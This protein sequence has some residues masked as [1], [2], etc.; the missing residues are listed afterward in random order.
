MLR[1]PLDVE[2]NLANLTVNVETTKESNDI[3]IEV[4]DDI[5]LQPKE[6]RVVSTV[7]FS[8]SSYSCSV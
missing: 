8:F 2:I 6:T 1:N 3:E 7:S 5:F 4:I